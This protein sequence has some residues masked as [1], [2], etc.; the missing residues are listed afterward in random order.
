M[1][2]PEVGVPRLSGAGY[3]VTALPY[4]TRID[5]PEGGR[6][7]Y[8][9][10]DAQHHLTE[11]VAPPEGHASAEVDLALVDVVEAPE[12]IGALRR[13]GVVGM[14]T[15]VV[16]IGGDHRVHSPAEFAR[17][18]KLWGALAPSDGQVLSCPPS[19]WPPPRV[20]GP[21]RM[22]V[23]GGARSGKS[24]EAERR[25]LGEPDV[26]YLA[27]GPKSD[28]DPAWAQRVAAH[29][30]RRPWWWRTEETLNVVGVLDA[31]EGAVLFDCVGTWLAGVMGECGLWED[32]PPGGAAAE[33]A[34]RI[35][36]LVASWRQ[37]T[38]RIVA[39]TNEVGSGV[40]PATA[41]GGMFRDLL[42]RLNQRLAAESEEV[43]LTVAGRVTRLP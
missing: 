25:L 20:R 15:A 22:L 18:A 2:A 13:A 11:T 19:T 42:G 4:G 43:V 6:L 9:R 40:V 17:R 34:A 30:Q 29:R 1:P 39:V 16:A 41:S 38:A 7:L 31:A 33:V 12:T 37:C 23:T 36:E 21:H 24:A 32:P 35:E 5:A 28:S 8:S 14:T 10:P 3:R 27:T 26:T